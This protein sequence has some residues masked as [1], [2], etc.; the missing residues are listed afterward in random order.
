MQPQTTSIYDPGVQVVDEELLCLHRNENL[1]LDT[2]WLQTL[3]RAAVERAAPVRYP[4]AA[5][6][7]LR[8]ALAESYDV[9]PDN[10][11]VGNGSDEVLSDLLG[12]L[13]R[14]F[15]TMATL[16]VCFKVYDLLSDRFQYARQIIPGDTFHTGRILPAA[17]Q[18]L[19]VVDSPN[20]IT[21]NR[22]TWEEL[23][24][25]AEPEGSFLIW[26]NAYGEFAG[27]TLPS[28]LPENVV[29]VRSFSKFY[30]LAGLR[31]GYCI[32]HPRVI[33]ELLRHK[34]AFNVNSVAQHAAIAALAQNER[35]SQAVQSMVACRT[36]LLARLSARGFTAG[37]PAGNHVLAT[38][39]DV[40]AAVLVEE[41]L[42]DRIAVRRFPGYPTDNY[43]RI[44]VP[45]SADLDRLT[46]ALDRIL[47]EAG[48]RHLAASPDATT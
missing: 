15:D 43:I 40:P 7:P 27:D 28:D 12:L 19:A 6:T 11:F 30:G 41:L 26:D 1:F 18:R 23:R 20:A 31:V 48:S 25:L 32:G 37:N 38:H 45:P 47:S 8:V 34:D 42:K 10:V 21:G 4:D 3:V 35:L 13:R 29:F 2:D 17:G 5:S 44:T 22:L 46:I 16:D 36:E 33:G 14:R 24:R 9:E 39:A